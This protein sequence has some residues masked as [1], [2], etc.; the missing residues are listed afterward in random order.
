MAIEDITYWE[1]I[2]NYEKEIISV[3][4]IKNSL[5]KYLKSIKNKDKKEIGDF[6]CG[7]GNAIPYLKDFKKIYEIDFSQNMLKL[8]E[9]K[10]SKNK[11]IE[12]IKGDN[13]TTKINPI[14]IILA[15]SSVMPKNYSEFDIIIENFLK[16]LKKNGEIIL[17][18]PSFESITLLYHLKSDFLFKQG[19]T[20]TEIQQILT[21]MQINQNYSPFG[22]FITDINLIQKHWLKEEIELRLLKYNF[23]KIQIEKLELDWEKQI[24]NLKEYKNYPK[25]WFWFVKIKI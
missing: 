14:D 25:L 19:K 6:G 1:K 12:F 15:V 23:K 7:V 8:A 13:K 21:Q 2:E 16:N 10:Y 18:L 22:Y 20:P 5:T 24:R 9:K 4:E 3:F 17:V 11:N